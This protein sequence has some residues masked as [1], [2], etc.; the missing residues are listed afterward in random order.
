[1]EWTRRRKGLS[2]RLQISL[3]HIRNRR[4]ACCSASTLAFNS[5]AFGP[6]ATFGALGS[7]GRETDS[8]DFSVMLSN[9]TDKA[10]S[11]NW[12]KNNDLSPV[13]GSLTW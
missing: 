1:M 3:R 6:L 4:R 2:Y 8:W 9:K 12:L 11:I 7:S 10:A 13:D 5:D